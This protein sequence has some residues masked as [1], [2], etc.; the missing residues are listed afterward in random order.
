MAQIAILCNSPP[1]SC[2]TFRSSKCAKPN[3]FVISSKIPRSST[4]DNSWPTVP[5]TLFG[6][7]STFCGFTATVIFCSF[8]AIKKSLSSPLGR[9][10]IIFSRSGDLSSQ[11]PRF[12]TIRPDSALIA[13][14]LPIPFGPRI[15]TTLS[16]EGVGNLN[17]LNPLRE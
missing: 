15:P 11:S 7:L 6:I 16:F 10:S 1:D 4:F 13:V 5:S 12:G 8:T 9:V 17:N 3:S 2:L 14:D